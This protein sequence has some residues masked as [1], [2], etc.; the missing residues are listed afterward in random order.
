MAVLNEFVWNLHL[1]GGMPLHYYAVPFPLLGFQ[2]WQ[3][4]SC[5]LVIAKETEIEGD[6]LTSQCHKN[7]C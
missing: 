7:V 6:S 4:L 2:V 1:M 3:G 5:V